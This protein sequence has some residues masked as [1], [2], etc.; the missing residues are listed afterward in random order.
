MTIEPLEVELFE[1][2]VVALEKLNIEVARLS[3]DVSKLWARIEPREKEVERIFEPRD[4]VNL[5]TFRDVLRH[6]EVLRQSIVQ[7]QHTIGFIESRISQIYDDAWSREEMKPW[8]KD[9]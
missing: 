4:I 6:F 2:S 8:L 9:R 7:S 3:G 5:K 1:K